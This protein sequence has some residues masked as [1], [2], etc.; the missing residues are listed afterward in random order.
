MGAVYPVGRL[1]VRATLVL[2]L[3]TLGLLAVLAVATNLW[4]IRQQRHDALIINITGRQRML[5]QKMAKEAALGLA[6]GRD[7]AS[8]V[9]MHETAHEFASDIAALLRGGSVAYG[10][11]YVL[12]P[13]VEDTAFRRA[14]ERV[15]QSW[16]PL[17]TAAHTVLEREPGSEAFA[18]ALLDLDRTSVR[19]L[20][21]IDDAVVRYQ[22]ASQARIARLRAA[23]LAFFVAG[24]VV[25]A[26]GS[27]LVLVHIVRPLD[28]V[29]RAGRELAAGTRRAPVRVDGAGELVALADAL[30]TLRRGSAGAPAERPPAPNDISLADRR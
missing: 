8:L 18:G 29:V 25:A 26:L 5:S 6:K 7:H 24:L 30:E 17:H 28:E 21:E 9:R 13:A 2:V 19:I 4:T 27:V 3:G 15:Q 20:D 11:M 10:P 12:V 1:G 14:M 23:Q 22:E 16:L